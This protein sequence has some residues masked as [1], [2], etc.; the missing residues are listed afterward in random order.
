VAVHVDKHQ[1]YLSKQHRKSFNIWS[2]IIRINTD[3]KSL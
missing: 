2:A 3:G 1:L